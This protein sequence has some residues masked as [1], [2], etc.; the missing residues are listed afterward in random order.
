LFNDKKNNCTTKSVDIEAKRGCTNYK[1]DM[2]WQK[3]TLRK[4]LYAPVFDDWAQGWIPIV[5]LDE[6]EGPRE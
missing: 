3:Y 5:R 4:Y 6:D 2:E 1:Q